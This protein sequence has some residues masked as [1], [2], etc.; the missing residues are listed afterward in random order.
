MEHLLIYIEKRS[1]VQNIR[2]DTLQSCINM[3]TH[4]H[5]SEKECTVKLVSVVASGW[6]KLGD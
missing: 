3:H 2:Y 1:K 4:I 5:I 6:G